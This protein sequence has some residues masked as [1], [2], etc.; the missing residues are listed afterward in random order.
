MTLTVPVFIRNMIPMLKTCAKTSDV[1]TARHASAAVFSK[2]KYLMAS[3]IHRSY[4]AGEVIN[5]LHAEANCLQMLLKKK[6]ING[7]KGQCLLRK[8]EYH[9]FV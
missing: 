6:K 2:N 4:I 5:T 1:C 3:N 8:Q 7:K 9:T